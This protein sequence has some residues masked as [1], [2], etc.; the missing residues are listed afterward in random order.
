MPCNAASAASGLPETRSPSPGFSIV[1]RERCP[2]R[3]STR[4]EALP[5]IECGKPLAPSSIDRKDL[6]EKA[7]RAMHL[8]VPET[9]TTPVHPDCATIAA[10]APSITRKPSPGSARS[11]PGR[12]SAAT[13]WSYLTKKRRL[14]AA[15]SRDRPDR[16]PSDDRSDGRLGFASTC[17]PW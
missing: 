14:A 8:D 12:S 1:A 10:S 4:E 15:H 6:S 5:G 17:L 2:R 16:D 7:H 13:Q 11:R 3:A 9:P